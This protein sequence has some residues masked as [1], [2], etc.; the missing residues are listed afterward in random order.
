M[1]C[2]S[3]SMCDTDPSVQ[4]L[5]RAVADTPSLRALILTM[6]PGLCGLPRWCH[7]GSCCPQGCPM[8]QV[9]PVVDMSG[10]SRFSRLTKRASPRAVPGQFRAVCDCGPL[11]V[12]VQDPR[13][14]S[15]SGRGKVPTSGSSDN[16][17]RRL[18]MRCGEEGYNHS[19]SC[20]L[21]L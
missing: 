15:G 20:A 21:I 11:A 14:A 19:F 5:L 8:S 6:I 17:A 10:Y 3:D 9:D 1:L 12:H 16:A 13:F 18:G 2:L 4:R 7:R